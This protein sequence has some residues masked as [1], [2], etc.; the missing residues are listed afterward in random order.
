M[1]LSETL[2]H[3]QIK[4]IS[5]DNIKFNVSDSE[6]YRKLTSKLKENGR[7][8]HSYEN[9]LNRSIKR[10]AK[11]LHHACDAKEII[12]DLQERNYKAID[13]CVKL[14]WRTKES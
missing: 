4:L 11:R 2:T 7:S 12:R 8:W 9:K 13:A 14:K 10:I 5:D 3:F 1:E 6:N